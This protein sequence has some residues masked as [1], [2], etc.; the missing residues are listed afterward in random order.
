MAFEFGGEAGH[1]ISKNCMFVQY[2]E[3]Q[4]ICLAGI[5]LNRLLRIFSQ[6]AIP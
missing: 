3:I 6:R 2:P 5:S 1:G 4:P